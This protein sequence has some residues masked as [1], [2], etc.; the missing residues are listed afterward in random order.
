M[1]HGAI[2]TQYGGCR[3]RSRLE[4]RWAVAFDAL[5]VR[6][7]YEPEGFEVGYRLSMRD[8]NFRYLPD[9][10]LPELGLW[11]EV[12][13]SWTDEECLRFLD[14]VADMSDGSCRQGGAGRHK[15]DFLIC[16]PFVGHAQNWPWHLHMHKGDIYASTWNPRFEGEDE[17]KRHAGSGDDSEIIATD[18]GGDLTNV[19]DGHRYGAQ[20]RDILLRGSSAPIPLSGVRALLAAQGARFERGESGAPRP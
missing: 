5:G 6:W 9:F 2:E 3:F 12:K 18:F 15:H 7:Q 10:W 4:A 17:S 20:V 13:G 14:A 11:V 8:E 1:K 16:G 19:T